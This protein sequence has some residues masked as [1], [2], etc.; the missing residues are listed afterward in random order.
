MRDEPDGRRPLS[1]AALAD[2]AVVANCAMNRE[3]GLTGVNSYARE[4]GFSPLDALAGSMTGPHHDGGAAGQGPGWLDLCC[5]SGRALIEAAGQLR[6][7][8]PARRAALIGVDLVDAFVHQYEPLPGL[9]LI[10]GSVLTYEPARAFDLITCVHGLHYVGDKLAIVSRAASW[11]SPAGRLAADLD[12][13][14]IRL[15]DGR[16]AGRPLAARL[17]AA[18]F[19]YNGRRHQLSCIG[20]KRVDLPYAFLGSDDRAGA[21]Y[22]G[23]PA[24]DSYYREDLAVAGAMPYPTLR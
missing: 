11:L 13:D 9:D 16:P 6:A 5:G 7:L 12:L 20:P 14:S 3:R 10:C 2:S 23:Q 15:A 17:R 8:A 4:L 1:D 21:N 22:T 19:S 18:G 24:V